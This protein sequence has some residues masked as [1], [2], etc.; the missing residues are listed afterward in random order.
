MVAKAKIQLEPSEKI[1]FKIAKN[2]LPSGLLFN[3]SYNLPTR[4]MKALV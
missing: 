4:C 3:S 2:P 1:H